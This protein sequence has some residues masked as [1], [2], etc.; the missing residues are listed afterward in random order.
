MYT[1]DS[2]ER[3]RLLY[4]AEI[5]PEATI[6]EQAAIHGTYMRLCRDALG[7]QHHEPQDD[8]ITYTLHTARVQESSVS[9]GATSSAESKDGRGKEGGDRWGSFEK[10]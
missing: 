2:L 8:I 3:S 9:D 5:W 6:N 1:A 10:Q 7:I 4:N